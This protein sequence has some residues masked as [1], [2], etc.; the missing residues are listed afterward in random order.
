ME[1][2]AQTDYK[3]GHEIGVGAE[4]GPNKPIRVVHATTEETAPFISR[5]KKT[6]SLIEDANKMI[7]GNDEYLA[8]NNEGKCSPATSL[9]TIN[10]EVPEKD[11]NTALKQLGLSHMLLG[12]SSQESL[13][14]SES[15][16]EI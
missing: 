4:F 15:G 10:T 5:N 7:D 9:S 1:M 14:Q 6:Q 2:E 16:T 12:G 8:F 3:R 11:W 13:T